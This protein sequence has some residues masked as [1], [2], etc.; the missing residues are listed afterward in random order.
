MGK[1]GVK[2]RGKSKVLKGGGTDAACSKLGDMLYALVVDEIRAMT[3]EAH[4]TKKDGTNAPYGSG[5]V[6]AHGG[7]KLEGKGGDAH[8]FEEYSDE[9]EE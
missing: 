4:E 1:G 2:R 5:L 9:N 8:N 6:K 7:R 3:I